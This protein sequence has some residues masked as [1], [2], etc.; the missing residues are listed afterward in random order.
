[1][2]VETLIQ[3]GLAQLGQA[4]RVPENAAALLAQGLSVTV[5][6]AR[7]RTGLWGRRCAP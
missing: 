1:M 5:V 2:N 4:G 3:T 7:F 6:F